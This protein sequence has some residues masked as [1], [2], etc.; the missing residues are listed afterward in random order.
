MATE[1]TRPQPSGLSKNQVFNLAEMVASKFEFEPGDDLYQ[2]VEGIG[3]EVL[4]EDTFLD[5]PEKSG[6]LFVENEDDFRIIISS[7]TSAKRDRFT[8]AHELGH[9]F[10]H[11]LLPKR[12]LSPDQNKMYALRKDSDRV[13]WEANW[14][15]AA[16]L[17]PSQEFASI[18]AEMEGDM[19]DIADYFDVSVSA[20][21]IRA[22][23]LDLA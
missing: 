8:I 16:F 9:L 1:Y 4:V 12:H 15:A 23:S 11:Y 10:L 18:H 14:F 13:E 19:E 3:G 20:A 21:E 22:K 6:S 5:D 17:M 7:H 2:F